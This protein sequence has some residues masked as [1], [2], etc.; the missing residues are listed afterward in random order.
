MIGTKL[1]QYETTAF[2]GKGG[3]GEVYRAHDGKLKRDVAIKILSS[4][5]AVAP[6]AHRPV[7]GR[8]RVI[9][10][11]GFALVEVMSV[12]SALCNKSVVSCFFD[13]LLGEV[14]PLS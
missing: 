5:P 6:D 11:A 3:M 14:I 7:L 8:G 13:K 4:E 12:G 10:V 9:A 2:P 1:E